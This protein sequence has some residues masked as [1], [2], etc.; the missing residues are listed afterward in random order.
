MTE[1]DPLLEYRVF[2]YIGD[3]VWEP[4]QIR[5]S[6]LTNGSSTWGAKMDPL[7]RERYESARQGGEYYQP[8]PVFRD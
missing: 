1:D 5:A 4:F 6:E 3:S 8:L 2:N 7:S